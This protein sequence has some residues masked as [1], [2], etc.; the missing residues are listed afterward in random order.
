MRLWTGILRYRTRP[1]IGCSKSAGIEPVTGCQ[2]GLLRPPRHSSCFEGF[3][4]RSLSYAAHL[5][6]ISPVF[7]CSDL[8]PDFVPTF[9]GSPPASCPVHRTRAI[10]APGHYCRSARARS[11]V[12]LSGFTCSFS[13]APCSYRKRQVGNAVLAYV[14]S[15][16]SFRCDS[17]TKPTAS[18]HIWNTD[19]PQVGQWR[20]ITSVAHD[21]LPFEGFAHR[22][23][24]PC[25]VEGI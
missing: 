16:A 4:S 5:A 8:A 25:G 9:T 15:D 3:C 21:G 6:F 20:S 14:Y 13:D 2:P 7:S 24:L 11:G 10:S 22:L 19:P 17:Q 12:A 23:T 1:N 18:R